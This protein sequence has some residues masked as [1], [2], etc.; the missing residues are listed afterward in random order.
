MVRVD[1]NICNVT[2]FQL[3]GMMTEVIEVEEKCPVMVLLNKAGLQKNNIFVV[4][5]NH[6]NRSPGNTGATSEIIPECP[7]VIQPSWDLNSIPVRSTVHCFASSNLWRIVGVQCRVR[8]NK[9]QKTTNL[10]EK[11]WVPWLEKMFWRLI[12]AIIHY[13]QSA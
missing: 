5:V 13:L 11:N 4:W 7:W 3:P 6:H 8:D 2:V 9:W 1:M 10:I 12:H